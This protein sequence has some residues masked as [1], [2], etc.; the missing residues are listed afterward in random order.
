MVE[1]KRSNSGRPSQI[2]EIYDVGKTNLRDDLR[3]PLARGSV[4]NLDTFG[5]HLVISWLGLSTG[6]TSRRA[7]W[8]LEGS[9]EMMK[10]ESTRAVLDEQAEPSIFLRHLIR[11]MNC[12]RFMHQKL[13]SLLDTV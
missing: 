11:W 12:G 7:S 2:F 3:E 4:R 13:S 8:G 10:D 6:K 9:R 5:M 1:F